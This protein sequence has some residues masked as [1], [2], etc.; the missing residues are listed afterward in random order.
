MLL[1][2]WGVSYITRVVYCWSSG[3]WGLL[4]S[5][6]ERDYVQVF[7]RILSMAGASWTMSVLH[8][9]GDSPV[10]HVLHMASLCFPYPAASSYCFSP[11]A[12]FQGP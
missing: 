12:Y 4:P 2:L 5:A 1:L 11:S 8:F 10:D 9:L 7:W 6:H 3:R